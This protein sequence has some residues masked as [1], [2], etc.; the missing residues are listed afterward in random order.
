M[1]LYLNGN[2]H[3]VALFQIL[4]QSLYDKVTPILDRLAN[5]K[6]AKSAF[7]SMLQKRMLQDEYFV[8]MANRV[9]AGETLS[10]ETLQKDFK[11]QEMVGET[12]IKIKSELF[13]HINVDNE[14]IPIVFELAQ[15]CIDTKKITNAELIAGIESEPSSEFWQN[16]DIDG[17][18]EALTKFR[19]TI[20]RRI[21]SGI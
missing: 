17:V 9:P 11:F 10:Q 2:A 7:E 21:K 5:S 13:E 16:Q 1:K 18:L 14:T 12:L 6:G 8:Q 4:T 19:A 3:D 15:V 20:L